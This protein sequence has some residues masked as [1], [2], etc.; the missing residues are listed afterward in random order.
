MIQ[1]FTGLGG[2]GYDYL[3]EWNK[4]E[5]NRY[6]EVDLLRANPKVRETPFVTG[7]GHH[8]HGKHIKRDYSFG[9]GGL[10]GGCW[11]LTMP[12]ALVGRL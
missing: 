6:S 3:G 8:S 4:R 1:L 10:M 11:P 9:A 7:T 5:N 2:M 12:L